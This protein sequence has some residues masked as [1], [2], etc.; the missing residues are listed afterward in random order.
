MTEKEKNEREKKKMKKRR[1]GKK[2]RR[3]EQKWN[4]EVAYLQVL[5]HSE[6]FQ[7]LFGELFAPR[8]NQTLKG[9][10]KLNGEEVKL[11]IRQRNS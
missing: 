3:R 2:T 5:E 10:A 1:E 9:C 7:G 6:S 11:L 8:K 4:R